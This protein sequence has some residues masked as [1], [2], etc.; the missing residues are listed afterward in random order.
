MRDDG[1]DILK[2]FTDSILLENK[3]SD[4]FEKFQ[5]FAEFQWANGQSFTEHISTFD[6][7]YSK[8]AKL[9]MKLPS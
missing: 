4:S 9:D 2:Q 7:M 1:L 8:I 5:E 3:L 6:S